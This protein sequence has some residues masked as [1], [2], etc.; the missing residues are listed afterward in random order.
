MVGSDAK[1]KLTDKTKAREKK[2]KNKT[3]QQLRKNKV[4]N[5]RK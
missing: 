4:D 5:S 1:D 3:L 2:M